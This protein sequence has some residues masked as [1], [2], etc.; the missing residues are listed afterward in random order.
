MGRMARKFWIEKEKR[1]KK[2]LKGWKWD[3]SKS[4]PEIQVM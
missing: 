1:K 2:P 3:P 4:S